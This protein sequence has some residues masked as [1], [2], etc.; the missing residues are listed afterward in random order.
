M[1]GA[2]V[3]SV[4]FVQFDRRI[5]RKL[6]FP[7]YGKVLDLANICQLRR[8]RREKIFELPVNFAVQNVEK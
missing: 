6:D 3:F 7:V 2:F 1:S 5:V 4:R 8:L